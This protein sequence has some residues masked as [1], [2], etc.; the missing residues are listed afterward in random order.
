M[1]P[2]LAGLAA[3]AGLAAFSRGLWEAHR[4]EVTHHRVLLP[5]I[6]TPLRILHLTDLHGRGLAPERLGAG[7]RPANLV[8]FTGDLV[9]RATQL[10]R[11]EAVLKDLAERFGP[12]ALR[13]A[14]LGNHDVRVG[15]EPVMAALSRAGFRVLLNEAVPVDGGLWVAGVDDPAEGKPDF[16]AALRDV[17]REA[18]LVLLAHGPQVLSAAV[19]NGIPL[20]LCGHTHGGQI[21]LPGLGAV[22]TAHRLGRRLDAGWFEHGP[23]R[24]YIC[25]GIG[26]VHLPLRFFCLP[27]VAVFD[28]YSS[29]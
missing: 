29:C 11:A 24:L 19:A 17:P 5:G 25:R 20:V 7:H 9:T 4:L 23:T 3:S 22:Y 15:R 6:Q 2:W 13:L 27:E 18:P 16:E 10:H 26:T 8:A 21:R 1:S 14:V 12:G 28:L